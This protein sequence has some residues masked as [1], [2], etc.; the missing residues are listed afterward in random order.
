M[1]GDSDLSADSLSADSSTSLDREVRR[2]ARARAA[3]PGAA[4]SPGRD[5]T[6]DE[7]AV[8]VK[9]ALRKARRAM[10]TADSHDD[11]EGAA[12]SESQTGG[13]GVAVANGPSLAPAVSDEVDLDAPRGTVASP[14]ALG[15][16]TQGDLARRIEAEIQSARAAATEKY[17]GSPAPHAEEEEGALSPAAATVAALGGRGGEGTTA[18]LSPARSR[19]SNRSVAMSVD[20]AAMSVDTA[21]AGNLSPRS[22]AAADVGEE[23]A[24]RSSSA[25]KAARERMAR[26]KDR[27]AAANEKLLRHSSGGSATPRAA[28]AGPTSPAGP[29]SR[30]PMSPR[31]AVSPKTPGQS[32]FDSILEVTPGVPREI[33]TGAASSPAAAAA[34]ASPVIAADGKHEE[35]GSIASPSSAARANTKPTAPRNT[36]DLATSGAPLAEIASPRNAGGDPA[37]DNARDGPSKPRE[38]RQVLFRH[39]YPLPP[40]PPLPRSDDAIVESHTAP[41][42]KV[43][44]KWAAPDADLAQL[45]EAAGEEHNLVRRSNACGALKVLASKDHNKPKLCRTTGLLDVLVKASWDDAVDSDALDARTR[46][47]ATLLYLA[48]P[49]D[50]RLIVARHPRVLEA[51]VKV[52]EEDTGE[53]RWRAT[54]ALATLAKTPGNRGTMG[55]VANLATVLG[56]L[57]ALGQ[58]TREEQEEEDKENRQ[59]AEKEG[60]P[61]EGDDA[62]TFLHEESTRGPSFDMSTLDEDERTLTHTYTGTF[63]EGTGTTFTEDDLTYQSHYDSDGHSDMGDDE[64]GENGSVGSGSRSRLDEEGEDG[65][66]EGYPSHEDERS[67][68]EEE[69]VEMQ[70]SSLKKLNI[71]NARDFLAKSQLSACAA[72]THL[73]RHCANAPILC[74]NEKLVTNVIL[75]AGAFDSPLHTRCIEMLCNF[76]RFPGNNSRLAAAPHAVETLLLCGRSKVSEDRT[77]SVRTLQNLCADAPSKVGLATGPVL[78]LL[79]T[80]AMRKDV[81]EQAAAVGALLNLS[82]EPGSIVPLTN[83]KTV[84]ATLVHLAHSPNTPGAVRKVACDALATIGLWLQTLASAGTVPE[85]VPFSPLPTHS[86]TGWLRWDD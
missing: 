53:A 48:E 67:L 6:E 8:M 22:P 51:L 73:T 68:G 43:N 50:N 15:K 25:R 54:S 70:I 12:P 84:V 78:S 36:N 24:P 26:S 17:Y 18:P 28:A 47:V 38:H 20:T 23:P 35:P 4:A 66:N 75:L 39:P 85:E 64:E 58:K 44:V 9:N 32:E 5:M 60:D 79:S 42:K 72:L 27:V 34:V 21:V 83:T 30:P 33:A 80:A 46:A 62:S 10:N 3:S 14:A 45:I 55:R 61:M 76:T 7:V 69:G 82:T 13:E 49:K 63:T 37:P 56:D 77:W 11:E 57:M 74:G 2:A 29:N 41:E 81:D 16:P 52:V 86:A 59:G 19:S 65:D 31:D 71:E 40:P 1:D